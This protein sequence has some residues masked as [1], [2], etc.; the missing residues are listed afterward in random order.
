MYSFSKSHRHGGSDSLPGFKTKLSVKWSR[1]VSFVYSF[2]RS[3]PRGLNGYIEAS[4]FNNINSRRW[5]ALAH[6]IFFSLTQ[7]KHCQFS[8]LRSNGSFES[9]CV[10]SFGL[11]GDFSKYQCRSKGIRGW[12]Q[13]EFMGSS[14]VSF[15]AQS[16]GS[17]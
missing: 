10:V 17:E 2:R 1:H 11:H 16:V 14:F 7:F 3:I 12:R 8:Y 9:V 6:L 15:A 5:A 13:R 4:N